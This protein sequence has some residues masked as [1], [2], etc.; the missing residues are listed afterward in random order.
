MINYKVNY[1]Q[2][3][4][5]LLHIYQ[6]LAI[7]IQCSYTDDTMEINKPIGNRHATI[8]FCTVYHQG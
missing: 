6:E 4:N 1:A 7:Q 3:L 2:L 5:H 8:N